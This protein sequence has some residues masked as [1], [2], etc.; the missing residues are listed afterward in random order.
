[1][2]GRVRG[3]RTAAE[4]ELEAQSRPTSHYIGSRA[5]E[6]CHA[7]LYAHWSK[8]PMANVV[9]DP[10]E[11]P[12]A[13]FPDLTTNK[14]APFKKE[15]VAFVY[16]SIWKQ[17]YFEKVGDDY[18]P[19][20]A[21]WDIVNKAWKPYFVPNGR[22]GGCP[23]ILRI[24][25]SGRRARFATAAIPWD[26]TSRPSKWLNGMWAANAAMGPGANTRRILRERTSRIPRT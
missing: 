7:E 3:H 10:R 9:R 16:G 14:I 6:K 24:I 11:H 21:Q 4:R 19:L 20:G 15:Q 8:T 1:M 23:F 2:T 12:E 18:F 17:R 26:T 5:C 13:I 22:I 25:S